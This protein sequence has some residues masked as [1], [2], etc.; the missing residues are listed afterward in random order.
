MPRPR[1]FDRQEVLAKA[2][3]IFWEQGIAETSVQDLV[4]GM[5]IGRGSLYSTFGSKDQLVAEVLA[6]YREQMRG[7]LIARLHREGSAKQVLEAFFDD[8][9]A[10]CREPAQPCCLLTRAALVLAPQ[11]DEVRRL[12]TAFHEDLVGA[13]AALVRRGIAQGHFRSELEPV[14]TARFLLTLM[15]G[16]G[17]SARCGG[18]ASGVLRT[19]WR[20]LR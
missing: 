8:L 7:Q 15:Q 20:A 19:A 2:M 18:D 17:V 4:E 11:H 16:I 13:F 14:D 10:S 12:L 1:E 6:C 3:H 9:L 5:G